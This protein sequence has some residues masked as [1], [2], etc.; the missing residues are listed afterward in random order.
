MEE[1]NLLNPDEIRN[2]AKRIQTSSII[3]EDENET[4]NFEFVSP[5]NY[6]ETLEVIFESNGRFGNPQRIVIKDFTGGQINDIIT[7]KE[8]KLLETVVSCLNENVIEPKGFKIENL[9][10]E[11]FFELLLGMKVAFDSVELR[12]RWYHSCQ[13]NVPNIKERQLSES[14]IDLREV[15]TVSIEEADRILR[16]EFLKKLKEMPDEEFQNFIELKYGKGVQKT[17]EEEANE[18]RIK[19]PI[20]IP[21]SE[22]TYQFSFMRIKYLIEAQRRA[23]K[24]IDHLIRI[25]NSKSLHGKSKEEMQAIREEKIE[26]L[27]REKAQKF[28]LYSQAFCLLG[29]VNNKTKEVF[30]FDTLDEKVKEYKN[31]SRS[32]MLNFINALDKIKYGVQHEVEL[33]CNLCE[34]TE[35]GFLQRIISPFELL[36]VSDTERDFTK[37]KLQQSTGF[38]FYF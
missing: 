29:K 34:G 3:Q 15:K 27:N 2:K 36:P 24:E 35:R 9:T 28:L 30:K 7:T 5:K 33:E 4:E 31:I 6:G 22:F 17:R 16:E 13:D 8:E 37:R 25:E 14:I 26:E 20:N 1:S 19:E 21:G 23:S 32:V 18:V 38:D 12:H 11:E 10:N